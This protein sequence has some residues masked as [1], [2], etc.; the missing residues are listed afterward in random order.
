[1]FYRGM[2]RIQGGKDFMFRPAEHSVPDNPT[3]SEVEACAV[4]VPQI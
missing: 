3:P 1:M 4:F 2:S